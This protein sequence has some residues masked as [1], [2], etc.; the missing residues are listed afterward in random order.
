MNKKFLA[1]KEP[2]LYLLILIQFLFFAK[3]Q[4]MNNSTLNSTTNV[5]TSNQIT[6]IDRGIPTDSL[7]QVWLNT[8][9]MPNNAITL[10]N[11]WS[12]TATLITGLIKNLSPIDQT[13]LSQNE[14]PVTNWPSFFSLLKTAQ[15]QCLV[16]FPRS[17]SLNSY[18]TTTIG[19]AQYLDKTFQNAQT[20][21]FEINTIM[22]FNDNITLNSKTIYLSWTLDSVKSIRNWLDRNNYSKVK[23]GYTVPRGI[24]ADNISWMQNPI[25]QEIM[26]EGN[27]SAYGLKN[28]IRDSILRY[29]MQT[30][31]LKI[32]PLILTFPLSSL[33]NPLGNPSAYQKVR[34]VL[35]YFRN[36]YGIHFLRTS[37]LV[38]V[39]TQYSYAIPFYPE[40]LQANQYNNSLT[41]TALSLIEQR[42]IFEG[43]KGTADSSFV[44][45]YTRKII[46]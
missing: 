23:I 39:M 28:G 15:N 20:N 22:V 4:K 42:S 8:A 40:T 46:P 35:V 9:I 37:N 11:T 7:Y 16:P 3:C 34:G 36:T 33:N 43:Y 10:S 5:D 30:G 25:I 1:I 24:L 32:K 12:N 14:T 29:I 13:P 31:L 2:K 45:S 18:N 38:F 19:I 41:G 17:N 21:G 26:M 27:P 6:S 44:D